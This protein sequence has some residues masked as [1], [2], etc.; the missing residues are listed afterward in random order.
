MTGEAFKR[1]SPADRPVPVSAKITL[2]YDFGD[3]LMGDEVVEV[4]HDLDPFVGNAD[5]TAKHGIAILTLLEQNGF[6]TRG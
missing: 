6:L 4:T 2:A 5:D 1:P 3:A